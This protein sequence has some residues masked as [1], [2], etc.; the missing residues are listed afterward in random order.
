MPRSSAART[1]S[2]REFRELSHS[3]LQ[4]HALSEA[5]YVD[6]GSLELA[7]ERSG[8]PQVSEPLRLEVEAEKAAVVAEPA[9]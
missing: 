2:E 9:A 8:C 5:R 7:A 4:R 1:S 3:D 6:S